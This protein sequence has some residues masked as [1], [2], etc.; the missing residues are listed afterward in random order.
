MVL[1]KKSVLNRGYCILRNSLELTRLSLSRDLKVKIK[2]RGMV[3]F[4]MMHAKVY[5]LSVLRALRDE[6]LRRYIEKK[7][8]FFGQ[9]CGKTCLMYFAYLK[10]LYHEQLKR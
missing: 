4:V 2:E 1:R 5:C 10:P 9:F 6:S 7:N 8:Y 3:G